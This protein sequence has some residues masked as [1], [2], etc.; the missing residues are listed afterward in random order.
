MLASREQDYTDPYFRMIFPK[1]VRLLRDSRVRSWSV[2][3]SPR[4]TR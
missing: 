1:A 4:M 2:T 3:A